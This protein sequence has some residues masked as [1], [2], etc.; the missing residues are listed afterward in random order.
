MSLKFQEDIFIASTDV[1]WDQAIQGMWDEVFGRLLFSG[2]ERFMI[3]V[4]DKHRLI[5]LHSTER[6]MPNSY[7]VL[8]LHINPASFSTTYSE[9]AWCLQAQAQLLAKE[10]MLISSYMWS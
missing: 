9:I 1:D 7:I 10:N 3:R 4:R 8:P 5:C 6:Y 2:S